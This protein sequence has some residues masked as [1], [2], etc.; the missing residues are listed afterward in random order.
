MLSASLNKT[1]LLLAIRTINIFLLTVVASFQFVCLLLFCYVFILLL[2]FL[3]AC[4]LFV[5]ALFNCLFLVAV[6]GQV[7][8]GQ[9]WSEFLTRTF[10]ASC[11]SARLSW[12]QVP[13]F[14]SSS[15]RDRNK[16]GEGSKGESACIGGYKR[17]GAFRP[18]SVAG[19][20]CFEV[21]WNLECPVGLS[22]KRN[23]RAIQ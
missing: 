6:L 10:R 3:F 1:F 22:Q 17:V 11:C 21:I 8:S 23:M 16:K 4:R 2:N 9:V 7:R 19:G 18:G 15:V 5:F 14:V 12:T 20:W 13:A